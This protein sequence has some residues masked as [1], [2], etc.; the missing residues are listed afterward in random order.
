MKRKPFSVS[1][2]VFLNPDFWFLIPNIRTDGIY[3]FSITWL[4]LGFQLTGM[5]N[6]DI[7]SVGS[8]IN[9]LNE[10]D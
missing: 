2:I 4:G 10:E 9:D 5:S 1:F 3:I 8:A 7:T 6:E